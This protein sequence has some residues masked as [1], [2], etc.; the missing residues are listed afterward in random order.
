MIHLTDE[1]YE[2]VKRNE[3]ASTELKKIAYK[4][5]FEDGLRAY[6]YYKDGVQYVG[7]TGMTLKE[8]IRDMEDTWN[9]ILPYKIYTE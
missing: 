1:E 2:E 7:T 5:G 9:F 4:R 6:A 3:K 8:A